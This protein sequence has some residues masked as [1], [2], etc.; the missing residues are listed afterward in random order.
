MGGLSSDLLD[1]AGRQSRLAFAAGELRPIDTR[2]HR[3]ETGELPADVRVFIGPVGAS[4]SLPGRESKKDNPFSPYDERV[5]VSEVSPTHVCL[6]NKFPVFSNHVLVV[7][8]AFEPQASLLTREDFEALWMCLERMGGVAFY[9]AGNVAGASQPH[10]HL[11]IVPPGE[12]E[13]ALRG[14][15]FPL[16]SRFDHEARLGEVRKVTFFSFVHALTGVARSGT[17][18]GHLFEIYEA[19]REATD[20]QEDTDPY[21]FLLTR[22]WMLLVPRSRERYEEIGINSLAFAGS[23][24]LRRTEHLEIVRRVGLQRMLGSVAKQEIR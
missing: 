16:V 5:K 22:D 11:Q 10:K 18:G 17:S 13:S 1:A 14:P 20:L 8:R 21:S 23:L 9:N 4:E 19:L 7:T 2:L 3:I 12:P 6:L 24:F 15:L